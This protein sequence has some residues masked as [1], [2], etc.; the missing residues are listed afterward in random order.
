[1]FAAE[2][3]TTIAVAG[4]PL[5]S[6]TACVTPTQAPEDNISETISFSPLGIGFIRKNIRVSTGS[7]PQVEYKNI[8]TKPIAPNEPL[9]LPL[10]SADYVFE[11]HLRVGDQTANC[12]AVKKAK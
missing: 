12:N 1:S 10:S 8:L 3:Q 7:L 9:V 5:Y 11:Y 2:P 6:H 4:Y